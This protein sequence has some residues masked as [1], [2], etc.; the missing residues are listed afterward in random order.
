M[1]AEKGEIKPNLEN[2]AGPQTIEAQAPACSAEGIQDFLDRI[3]RQIGARTSDQINQKG[4]KGGFF[5]N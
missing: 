4:S 5:N 3:R 1:T 2:Q